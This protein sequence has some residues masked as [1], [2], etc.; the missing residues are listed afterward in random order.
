MLPTSR[1]LSSLTKLFA[2]VSLFAFAFSSFGDPAVD[3]LDQTDAR[4]QSVIA[5]QDEVTPS[6]MQ[7]SEILGT[8]VGVSETGNPTLMVYVNRDAEQA[9]RTLPREV[10]GTPVQVELM[11]EVRAMGNTAKQ[12]PPISL[13]T[14]GGWTYDLANGYCCGGTLGALVRIG[15]TLYILS[16]CH[17]LEG[18]KVLGGNNRIAQ[19]GDPVIQAGLIDEQCNRNLAQTVGTLVKRMSLATSNTDCAIATVAGGMVRTDGAILG[20]GTIS[21]NTSAA[22]LNQHV[23]K[24]GRTSGLT[25][26]HVSGLN[27]TVRVAFTNECNGGT[28]YKT[29]SGQIVVANPSSGFLRAGDSGSLMVEDTSSNP[30]AIGLLFAGNNTEAFA[31]PIGQVLSFLG[32]TMVGN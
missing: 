12:T 23:K 14:S 28:Y 2:A 22:S 10:R 25:H 18:D 16:A 7:R 30:R 24:S 26:S 21:H 29:F 9:I 3:V 15:S 20:I 13:G 6:L 19:T 5:A 8:A 1:S 17:V 27:A 11:D 31:N 4:V 32:A